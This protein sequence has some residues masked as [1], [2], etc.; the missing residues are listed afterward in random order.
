[1]IIINIFCLYFEIK[2]VLFRT[3]N[4]IILKEAYSKQ[5][6]HGNRGIFNSMFLPLMKKAVC[7]RLG[8]RRPR[9]PCIKSA[10]YFYLMKK[11]LNR[12]IF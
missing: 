5:G 1:M 3:K 6:G 10:P 12:M 8:R 7:G 4:I 9:K 2:T 11:A